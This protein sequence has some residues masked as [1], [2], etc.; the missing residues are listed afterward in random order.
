MTERSNAKPGAGGS[1][2]PG[3]VVGPDRL[4]R[5]GWAS[6]APEYR[7]YHDEEWGRPVGEDVRIF[8][9]LCLEGFQSGLS[10][11]T[12]LR[13]RDGFRRAFAGFDPAVI[14]D[15]GEADVTR[16]LAD[17]SIIRNRAKVLAT[18]ANARALLSLHADGSSLGALL[19][20]YERPDRGTRPA[21]KSLRDVPGQSE[22]SKQ[23]SR[24]LRRSGFAFVGPTTVYATMQ[25]LGVVDDHLEGCSI[26][27]AAEADRAGFAPPL[28]SATARPA[29][30]VDTEP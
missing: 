25:S 5:C 26:R 7:R 4:A 6:S 9:K 13:K 23:L 15:Y 21:P 16:L 19:W 14:A 30:P 27:S 20:S 1:D 17:A 10:W 28:L 8:E 3:V 11:L 24:E 22:E 2:V 18:I 29:D 12:V